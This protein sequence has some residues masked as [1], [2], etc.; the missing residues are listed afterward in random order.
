MSHVTTRYNYIR[1]FNSLSIRNSSLHWPLLFLLVRISDGSRGT[2]TISVSNRR[3]P[4]PGQTAAMADRTGKLLLLMLLLH[5]V[6]VT[7]SQPNLLDHFLSWFEVPTKIFLG[8]L[9]NNTEIEEIDLI[10]GTCLQYSVAGITRFDRCKYYGDCCATTPVK[11]MEQVP[12]GAFTCHDGIYIIDSCPKSTKDTSL[13][14]R[15]ERPASQAGRKVVF[16]GSRR[17]FSHHKL[18]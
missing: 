17:V 2:S 10:N 16:Y 14:E 8:L 11:M 15:C 9:S 5:G 13:R 12:A 6:T 4:H 18:P 1:A 3:L 7:T